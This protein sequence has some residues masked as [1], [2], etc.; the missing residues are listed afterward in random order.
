[1]MMMDDLACRLESVSTEIAVVVIAVVAAV[2]L[3]AESKDILLSA[4]SGLV[5]FLSGGNK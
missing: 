3:G 2:V 1:M 5:G 4:I